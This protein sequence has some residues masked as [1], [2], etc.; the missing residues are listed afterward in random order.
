MA[1]NPVHDEALRVAKMVGCDMIVNVTLDSDYRLTGIFV[2]DME[3]AHEA[4][5]EKLISYAAIPV[6]K[7]YDL[8]VTHAGFVGIN[9]Y[10]AAK[11][12]V[13]AASMIKPN[14]ICVLAA[15]HPDADPIGGSNYQA[16]LKLLGESGQERYLDMILSPDWKFVPEQWEAQ[17]WTRLFR[18]TPV[19]NLIYCTL[20][21]SETDFRW[22]PGTDARILGGTPTSLAH[23]T[24]N[25]ITHSVEKLQRILGRDPDIAILPDGPYGIP[26]TQG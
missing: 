2:G 5:V 13:I 12:A 6:N 7:K 4:A 18:L 10:Q 19:E 20:D 3:G 25:A 15:S 8:V 17:M 1:G 16:M 26:L 9:H 24:E 11:G 23:L 14:G 22:L 21:I